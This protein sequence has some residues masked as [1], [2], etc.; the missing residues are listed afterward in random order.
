[1]AGA[2]VNAIAHAVVTRKR[3][4]MFSVPEEH[5]FLTGMEGP[6]IGNNGLFFVPFSFGKKELVAKVIASDGQFWEHVS[7]TL[8]RNRCPTWD[9]MCKIKDMF[10]S[11]EDTVIQF[12]P[13][14]A[15]YVNFHP[16]CLH[17]WRPTDVLL[18]KPPTALTGPQ[19]MSDED[20]QKI[21][22]LRGM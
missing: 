5:R 20:I 9:E 13:A 6:D 19:D 7:V 4:D 10:W 12:H 3:I 14:K 16:Y 22:Q 17:M 21:M 15:D 11:E 2:S 18:P 1:M 8:N